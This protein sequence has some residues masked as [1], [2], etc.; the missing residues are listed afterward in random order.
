[1][2][3]MHNDASQAASLLLANSSF[4]DLRQIRVDRSDNSLELTGTVRSF[5]HKQL[6]QESIRSVAGGM[7]VVNHLSVSLS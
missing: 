7:Q 4:R 6:A 2:E 3:T 5:Y 1:M